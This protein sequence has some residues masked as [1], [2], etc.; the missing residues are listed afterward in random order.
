MRTL[1]SVLLI[2]CLL[3]S[4]T[5]PAVGNL[6]YVGV[7]TEYERCHNQRG[8]CLNALCPHNSIRVGTCHPEKFF[9]CKKKK[10]I[11]RK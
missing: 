3:F 8:Y 11:G 10:L 9:C 2:C 1:C 6:K 7:Q 5:T 4:S